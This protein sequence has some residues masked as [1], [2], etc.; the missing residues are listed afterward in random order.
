M[1]LKASDYGFIGLKLKGL[2]FNETADERTRGGFVLKWECCNRSAGGPPRV[3]YKDDKGWSE[4][5]K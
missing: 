5:M 4:R 2:I 3:E 1:V